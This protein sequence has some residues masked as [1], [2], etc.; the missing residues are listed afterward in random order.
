MED[1]TGLH[2][3]RF[4]PDPAEFHERLRADPVVAD[5]LGFC[6][7]HGIPLS[8]FFGR[9][10]PNPTD[11]TEPYWLPEDT[12]DA[13]GHRAWSRGVCT[14]CGLHER[15]WENERDQPYV[16]RARLCNGCK[17]VIEAN[18]EYVDHETPQAV[19]MRLVHNEDAGEAI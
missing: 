1:A 19:H 11:P 3:T 14:Q 17:E 5:A 6:A 2:L 4:S 15:D 8:I 18:E 10:Y 12:A 16:A 13:L 7:E 9:A